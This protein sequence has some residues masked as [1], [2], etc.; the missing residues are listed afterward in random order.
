MKWNDLEKN[1]KVY[2]FI[3][4]FVIGFFIRMADPTSIIMCA[5]YIILSIKIYRKDERGNALGIKRS[6]WK[7]Y[8][9][10]AL[11]PGIF[12]AV[13]LPF[14]VWSLLCPMHLFDELLEMAYGLL[15]NIWLV[16]FVFYII[17]G[18]FS[19][20]AEEVYFRG[21]MQDGM[22]DILGIKDYD[23]MKKLSLKRIISLLIV[24]LLFG[25][26][27]LNLL[28]ASIYEWFPVQPDILFILIGFLSLSGVG[29]LFG[30][31]RIKFD[32]LYPAIICHAISNFFMIFIPAF[33]LF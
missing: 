9:I 2:L 23:N 6:S 16:I 26:S 7:N 25:F 30:I 1:K 21:F 3:T 27:H 32:S 4:T 22:D 15:G 29:F 31:L 5:F 11:A 8:L 12:I 33:I 19:V 28:W 14:Y 20:F 10:S 13:F 18:T 24:S 17:I